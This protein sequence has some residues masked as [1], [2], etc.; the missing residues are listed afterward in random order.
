MIAALPIRF[1]SLAE[2]FEWELAK[3]K[4]R[5]DRFAMAMLP[6]PMRSKTS[7]A[8]L[9]TRLCPVWSAHDFLCPWP[10][11]DPIPA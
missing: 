7:R 3:R 8:L 10:W 1:D 5:A 4:R 6:V 9:R 11:S 2:A